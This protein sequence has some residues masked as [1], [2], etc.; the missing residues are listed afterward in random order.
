MGLVHLL[1][2]GRLPARISLRLLSLLLFSL[3]VFYELASE[4]AERFHQSESER[5]DQAGQGLRTCQH[6]G[7]ECPSFAA[8][9]V[10]EVDGLKE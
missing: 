2:P 6:T 4:R 7:L 8:G 1:W 5:V 9:L 10:V 3:P